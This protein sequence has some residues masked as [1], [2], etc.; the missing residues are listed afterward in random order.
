MSTFYIK[1]NQVK[2]NEIQIIGDDVNHIKNVLRYKKGDIID[3]C[4]EDGTIFT[5]EIL[6]LNDKEITVVITDMNR[7]IESKLNITLFQALPKSDKMD[8]IIQKC[9]ELGVNEIVPIITDRVIV[10]LDKVAEEKKVARWNKIALE[11]SKQCGRQRVPSV[12]DVHNLKN[13]IEKISKYDIVLV[14]YE[15]EKN[16][17]L[18][19]VLKSKTS[20]WKNIAILIGPEGGLSENDLKQLD[21]NNTTKISLGPRI[22]RTETAGFMMLAILMYE[23]EG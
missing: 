20:E 14:A 10:K 21:F 8:L 4:S 7:T 12:N 1:N 16:N 2:G 11:A 3:I 5:G 23:L 17:S 15:G 18:K 13:L 6:L 22:L 9:T 19:Q